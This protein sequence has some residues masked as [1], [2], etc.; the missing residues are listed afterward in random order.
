MTHLKAVGSWQLAVGSWLL[1]VV[2]G[3]REEGYSMR[4]KKPGFLQRFR[5]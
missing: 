5:V 3:K 1:A 4:L 2:R